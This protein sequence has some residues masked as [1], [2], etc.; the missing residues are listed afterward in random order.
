MYLCG[1]IL[2]THHQLSYLDPSVTWSIMDTLRPVEDSTV[3]RSYPPER[4]VPA[5]LLVP[6][7]PNTSYVYLGPEPGDLDEEG[8]GPR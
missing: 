2:I 8:L 7:V 3:N 5:A 1:P 4:S 6:S